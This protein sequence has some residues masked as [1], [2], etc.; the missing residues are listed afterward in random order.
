[1]S[2][3]LATPLLSVCKCSKVA[4][5]DGNI[6]NQTFANTIGAQLAA[7]DG[8]KPS[9]HVCRI[10]PDLIPELQRAEKDVAAS[11][12]KKMPSDAV[13]NVCKR[14]EACLDAS[15]GHFVR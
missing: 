10:E 5:Q 3:Y 7:L 11:I 1:M 6:A 13:Q 2:V 14:A 15:G 8:C 12:T 4:T 9:Q